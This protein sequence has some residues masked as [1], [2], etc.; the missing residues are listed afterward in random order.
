[1]QEILKAKSPYKLLSEAAGLI[2]KVQATNA[3]LVDAAR[4]SAAAAIGRVTSRV[5]DELAAHGLAD[6]GLAT[7]CLAPLAALKDSLARQAS[8]AHL[9]RAIMTGLDFLYQAI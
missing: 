1:M 6:D 8:V 7:T 9:T 4:T 3:A 5:T 2:E